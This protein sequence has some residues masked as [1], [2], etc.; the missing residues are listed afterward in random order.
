MDSNRVHVTL[1]SRKKRKR[2]M[3][4]NHSPLLSTKVENQNFPFRK[5][6]SKVTSGE[7]NGKEKCGG[8]VYIYIY[9]RGVGSGCCMH[10]GL[11]RP[12]LCGVVATHHVVRIDPLRWPR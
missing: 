5:K 8:I 7:K 10:E 4:R 2:E 9:I 1:K 11:G 3:I 12:F 6:S